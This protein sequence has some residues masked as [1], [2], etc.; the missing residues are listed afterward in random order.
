M[1]I[2]LKCTV[3]INFYYTITLHDNL[4]DLDNRV[5]GTDKMMVLR[6]RNISFLLIVVGFLKFNLIH[7]CNV[8]TN[9]YT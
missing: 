9:P 8:S 5:K 4:C 6:Y 7:C 1:N 2:F 3:S